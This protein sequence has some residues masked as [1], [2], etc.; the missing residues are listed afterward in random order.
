[1]DILKKNYFELFGLKVSTQL[2]LKDLDEKFTLLQKQF[3]PD[4]YSNSS[5]TEKRIALQISSYLNDGYITLREFVTRVEYILKIKDFNTD[6]SKTLFDEEF[7]EE[8]IDLNE[9]IE[10]LKINKGGNDKVN[11]LTLDLTKKMELLV[12]SINDYLS[13]TE[14]DM[15]WKNLAKYK[16][17]RNHLIELEPMIK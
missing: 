4:K 8:Q 7:L 12:V 13:R 2:D 3:H 9:S 16:F 10:Q 15:V 5:D 6:E 1:M 11:V 14:Y 17:Y